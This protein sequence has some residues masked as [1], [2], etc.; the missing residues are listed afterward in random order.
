MI[1][2]FDG[3]RIRRPAVMMLRINVTSAKTRRMPVS[4]VSPSGGMSIWSTPRGIAATIGPNG[5]ARET[6]HP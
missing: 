6:R 3:R 1:A 2:F 4:P 5:D